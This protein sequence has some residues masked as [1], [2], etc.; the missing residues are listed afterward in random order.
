MAGEITGRISGKQV[1]KAHSDGFN[2]ALD[3]ALQKLQKEH[4]GQRFQV[5]YFI[6]VTPNPGG[7]G[8]Y[9]VV[10]DPVAGGGGG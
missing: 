10:L 9:S 4:H 8:E 6:K 3:N 1:G 5:L 7:V 2:R